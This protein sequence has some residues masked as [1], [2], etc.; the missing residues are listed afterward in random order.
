VGVAQGWRGIAVIGADEGGGGTGCT[1]CGGEKAV[2]ERARSIAWICSGV[3]DATSAANVEFVVDVIGSG[4]GAAAAAVGSVGAIDDDGNEAVK[5]GSKC[6]SCAVSKDGIDGLE[7]DAG[8]GAGARTV[9]G[10]G[11]A[12][13]TSLPFANTQIPTK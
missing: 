11:V 3:R 5:D 10:G 7:L 4:A 12:G 1:C 8:A 2:F 6:C 13:A 9:A